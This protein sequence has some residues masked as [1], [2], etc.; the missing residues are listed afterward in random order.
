MIALCQ[1]KV[2]S[3]REENIARAR[4]SIK[5]ATQKGAMLMILP[6]SIIYKIIFK[7]VLHFFV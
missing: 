5:D 4:K 3:D 1:L 7:V 6:I 2:T